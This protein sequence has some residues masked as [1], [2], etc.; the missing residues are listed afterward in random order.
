MKSR[1]NRQPAQANQAKKQMKKWSGRKRKRK[2]WTDFRSALE[3]EEVKKNG[4]VCS[5]ERRQ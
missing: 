1:K 3:A 5:V 2:S 4:K